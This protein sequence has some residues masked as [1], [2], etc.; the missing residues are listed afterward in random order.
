MKQMKRATAWIVAAMV[1]SNAG[2]A[3]VG[4]TPGSFAVGESGEAT[5]SIPIWVPQGP[6]GMQPALTLEYGSRTGNGPLGVGWTLGGLS[7]IERCAR[8][9]SQ[10][11]TAGPIARLTSLD[12]YCLDG[13]RLRQT[14][15][16]SYGAANSTYQT[17]LA[18]FALVTAS[19][20]LTGNGPTYFTVKGKDGLTFEYGNSVDSR[21]VPGTSSTV[22]RWMLSRVS[23]RDGNSYA[24][25]WNTATGYSDPASISWTPVSDG[26]TTYTYSATFTY[27]TKS[28]VDTVAE[29]IAGQSI[30]N[31]KRLE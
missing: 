8:S 26:S 15:G 29:S 16:T 21:V 28:S 30:S 7:A 5:Y 18:N 3:A 25:T 23:D 11:G 10:D 4:R 14:S 1:T 12:R 22:L 31:A 20:T 24:I 6:R 17:E 2:F 19:S 27:S 9:I 13:V